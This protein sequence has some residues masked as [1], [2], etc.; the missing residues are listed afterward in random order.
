GDLL[1]N[2]LRASDGSSGN[3]SPFGQQTHF[4]QC[5]TAWHGNCD[6]AGTQPT[7][8]EMK[9]KINTVLV[10]LALA[11]GLSITPAHAGPFKF[12]FS[13]IGSGLI[14]ATTFTNTPVTLDVS[15]TTGS[16]L[17]EGIGD[18]TLDQEV[19]VSNN[20]LGPITVETLAGDTLLS[21]DGPDD[22]SGDVS[23]F[24]DVPTSG[25][26]VT[27]TGFDKV[28]FA[29]PEPSTLV[30]LLSVPAVLSLRRR[31]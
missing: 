3:A 10:S 8:T 16:L 9:K 27:L 24:I 11:M 28:S 29:V 13:G 25:G 21:L 26:L 31:A 19:T 1:S 14:G 12:R 2:S 5:V 17:I 7:E 4:Q 6:I 15:G 22:E 20:A 18:E 23:G 30:L